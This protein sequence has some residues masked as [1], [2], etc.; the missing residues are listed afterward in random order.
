MVEEALIAEV[1]EFG[2][3]ATTVRA[4]CARS[5][6]DEVAFHR[7]FSDLEDCFCATFEGLGQEFL[8][9]LAA[10]F[11]GQASWRDQL[12]AVAYAF[13][14]YLQED[15]ARARLTAVEA[16]NAGERAQVIRDEIF[17]GLYAF[18]DLGRQELRDPESLTFATAEAIGGTIYNQ[19]R[20]R[21]ETGGVATLTDLVPKMMYTAV[22]P[23][24]GPE[25]ASEELG[26]APPDS[27]H[28]GVREGC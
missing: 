3:R 17:G 10:A 4:V 9:R 16:L 1:G 13:L 22:L 26:R 24:L 18:I 23:Y 12:R 21:I 28:P 8:H 6:V 15:P 20:I 27:F 11:D 25:A 19:I 7:H 2:Y 5:G 14:E